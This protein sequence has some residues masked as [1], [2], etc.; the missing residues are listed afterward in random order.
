MKGLV[1]ALAILLMLEL[2]GMSFSQTEEP[3]SIAVLALDAT[4][5]D[6]T[7][8][9]TITEY[10]RDQLRLESRLEVIDREIIIEKIKQHKE[11]VGP[12]TEDD[13]ILSVGKI[14]ETRKVIAGSMGKI[15]DFFTISLT[16]FDTFDSTSFGIA[17]DHTGT[18]DS[19]QYETIENVSRSIVEKIFAEPEDKPIPITDGEAEEG[20]AS[21]WYKKWWVWASAAGGAALIGSVAIM[22]GSDD[23]GGTPPKE[24]PLPT[25][26]DLP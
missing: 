23:K 7:V 19:F 4:G 18:K 12:F 22:T 25:P 17:D 1:P 6:A 8:A 26:P 15:G 13:E 14:L 9:E 10:L 24:N 2:W 20:K 16:I 3:I 11:L 21:P 5:M